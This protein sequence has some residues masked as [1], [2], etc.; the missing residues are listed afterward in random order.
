MKNTKRLAILAFA[1][2]LVFTGMI[3]CACS[4]ENVTTEEAF[5]DWN[6]D[7]P[8]SI[9]DKIAAIDGVLSIEAVGNNQSDWLPERYIVMVEQQIDWSDPDAGTIMASGNRTRG[10][11]GMVNMV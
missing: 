6:P 5:S 4:E 7:S 10:D 11:K 3:P 1:I 2:M 8:A 9:K